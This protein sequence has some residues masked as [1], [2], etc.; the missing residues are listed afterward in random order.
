M[1]FA[2]VCEKLANAAWS[3]GTTAAV[4]H[5]VP[6]PAGSALTVRGF[7]EIGCFAAQRGRPYIGPVH[8]H[9]YT[10]G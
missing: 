3:A 8:S 5:Y 1:I 10:N 2:S 6:A 7:I 9:A 4:L